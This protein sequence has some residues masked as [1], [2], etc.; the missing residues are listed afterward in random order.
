MENSLE[1]ITLFLDCLTFKMKARFSCETTVNMYQS[2][3]L[4]SQKAWI[5]IIVLSKLVKKFHNFYGTWEYVHEQGTYSTEILKEIDEEKD[6][7]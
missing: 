7:K 6:K 1:K 5:V 4:T 3:R 2:K